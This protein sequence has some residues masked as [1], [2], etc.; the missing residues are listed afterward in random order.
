MSEE[1]QP[2]TLDKLPQNAFDV[3]IKNGFVC[4]YKHRI[5]VTAATRLECLQKI[6][7]LNC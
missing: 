3:H 7:K 4:H 1:K 5:T 2:M 6:R